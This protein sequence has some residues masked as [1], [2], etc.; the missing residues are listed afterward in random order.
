[1]NSTDTAIRHALPAPLEH[2]LEPQIERAVFA[3]RKRGRSL[4]RGWQS[5]RALKVLEQPIET[6]LESARYY[7]AQALEKAA[8]ARAGASVDDADAAAF[9]LTAMA[10]ALDSLVHSSDNI[11]MKCYAAHPR[12]V[13]DA[14]WFYGQAPVCET[15]LA[16]PDAALQL[17]G[18]ELTGRMTQQHLIPRIAIAEAPQTVR[19]QTLGLLDALGRSAPKEIT[20]WLTSSDAKLLRIALDFL[21]TTGIA[22]PESALTAAL[23]AGLKQ[24]LEDEVDA[25]CALV[26]IHRPPSEASQALAAVPLPADLRLRCTAFLGSPGLLLDALAQID[27]QEVSLSH[28]QKNFLRMTLGEIPA[29]LADTHGTQAARGNALRKLAA[30]VFERNGCANIAPVQLAGW[31]RELLA[32][33]LWPL[34]QIRLRGGRPWRKALDCDLML[35]ASHRM[36]RWLYAEYAVVTGR[37]FPLA[38]DDRASRQIEVLETL[39]SLHELLD[40]Q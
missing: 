31:S 3:Y 34:E 22:V 40:L 19:L 6:L 21:L 5:L 35:E 9:V 18:I 8:A 7:G 16:Q 13:R 10:Q 14:L 33:P 25:A 11:S 4:D 30:S 1:L 39:K 32:G 2:L 26:C 37:A 17:L 38:A 24:E 27:Q 12:A 28:E 15:L 23:Q 36:R 20:A 29:D